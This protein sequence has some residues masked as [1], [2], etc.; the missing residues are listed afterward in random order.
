M[1]GEFDPVTLVDDITVPCPVCGI[2]NPYVVKLSPA[3]TVGDDITRSGAF[4][5]DINTVVSPELSVMDTVELLSVTV[6][7]GFI[8]ETSVDILYCYFF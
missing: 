6:S 7:L 8:N 3:T 2:M 4:M 5:L 1:N